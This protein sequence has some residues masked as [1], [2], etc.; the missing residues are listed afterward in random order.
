M[1]VLKK[2][3]IGICLTFIKYNLRFKKPCYFNIFTFTLIKAMFGLN[4][5]ILMLQFLFLCLLLK[6]ILYVHILFWDFPSHLITSVQFWQS[7]YFNNIKIYN[8]YTILRYNT[9]KYLHR[10][11]ESGHWIIYGRLVKAWVRNMSC[12]SP[13]PSWYLRKVLFPKLIH[14]T[15]NDSGRLS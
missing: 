4:S 8:I 5:L 12:G 7:Y 1:S 3:S 11:T 9:N 15:F 10:I 2:C 14:P 13:D 6:K